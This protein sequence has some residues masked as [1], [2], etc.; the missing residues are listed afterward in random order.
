MSLT[1]KV[2]QEKA[3]IVL[4]YGVLFFLFCMFAAPTSKV[5]NQVFYLAVLLPSLVSIKLLLE[6]KRLHS[7][8]LPFVVVI[9]FWAFFSLVGFDLGGWE[10]VAKRFKHAL[11]VVTFICAIYYLLLE[12]FIS[13][14]KLVILLFCFALI[15]S[16]WSFID[17]YLLHER[18]F[19]ARLF[20]VLRLNSPIFMAIILAIYG[21]PLMKLF[22]DKD[23]NINGLAVFFLIIFFLYFYNSRSAMTGLFI[24]LLGMFLYKKKE[25]QQIMFISI[26]AFFIVCLVGSYYFGNILN[27]G[28]S[29]RLDI[30][31]SSLM[32]TVDCGLFLGCG[33]GGNSEITIESG[34]TFQHSHN[35][36]LSHFLNTGLLGLLSLLWVVG[37]ITYQGFKHNAIMVLGLL[38]GI[39]ALMF[40]GNALL[41]NPDDMW[42]IFWLPLIMTYWEINQKNHQGIAVVRDNVKKEFK[43]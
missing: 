22:F 8:L 37:Y 32:K 23:K 13:V 21:V 24:G 10:N 29:Y 4:P 34:R 7:A 16:F 40:E 3:L 30:W 27:R 28:V 5:A 12:G 26:F 35:I 1:W 39:A 9:V 42:L 38:V 31:V 43:S 36:F 18:S 11:Y 17:F 41:T 6:N 25:K 19:S 14:E 2:V 33:F 20:P 15:Y